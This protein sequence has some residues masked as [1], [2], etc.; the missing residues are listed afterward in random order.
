VRLRVR[1][2]EAEVRSALSTVAS[3]TPERCVVE[4]DASSNHVR[5]TIELRSHLRHDATRE[6]EAADASANDVTTDDRAAAE[7]TEQAVAAIV[8]AGL[9]VL[10]VVPES[11]L[12][13]V[14]AELTTRA[15]GG[16]RRKKRGLS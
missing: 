13:Q 11:S 12:E 1:G 8:G 15:P 6:G 9:G 10:E 7:L 2:A 16:A 4:P 3:L 5:V 14:F